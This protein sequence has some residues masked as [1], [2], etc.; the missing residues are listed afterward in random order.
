MSRAYSGFCMGPPSCSVAFSALSGWCLFLSCWSRSSEGQVQ[1]DSFAFGLLQTRQPWSKW[2]QYGHSE[3]L[4]YPCRCLQF[5][6]EAAQSHI[7]FSVV[8]IP[9][10]VLGFSVEWAVLE[11]CG[12]RNWSSCAA[13]WDP[14]CLCA[15]CGSK[16]VCEVGGSS[17]L[18]LGNQPLHTPTQG[19]LGRRLSTHWAFLWYNVLHAPTKSATTA[20]GPASEQWQRTLKSGPKCTP[21][22]PGYLH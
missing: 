14:G 7:F 22:Y 9:D 15:K 19:S 17:K 13:A 1:S 12:C 5:C 4:H 3:S 20:P 6:L 2:G 10:L 18:P 16:L 8:F 21:D 11:H